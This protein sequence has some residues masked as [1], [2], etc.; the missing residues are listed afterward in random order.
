MK[1]PAQILN[2]RCPLVKSS[3]LLLLALLTVLTVTTTRARAEDK[4]EAVKENAKV[5]PAKKTRKSDRSKE[6]VITGSLIPQDVRRSR[7][8]V[9]TFPVLIISK[10][11]IQRS[12]R[13]TLPGV[14]RQ[15]LGR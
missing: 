15:Q 5:A 11:D 10:D 6:V 14:L 4:P 9:T 12:G 13:A 8:P 3:S 7:I 2:R 1:A